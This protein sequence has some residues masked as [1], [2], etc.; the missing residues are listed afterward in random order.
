[1]TPTKLPPG[2][3][4][5]FR[6]I[7]RRYGLMTRAPAAGASQD[8]SGQLAQ[9]RVRA[10]GDAMGHAQRV[11]LAEIACITRTSCTLSKLICPRC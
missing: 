2:L 7:D 3:P 10:G 9:G 11:P 8:G 4:G 5:R 6:V 1:M